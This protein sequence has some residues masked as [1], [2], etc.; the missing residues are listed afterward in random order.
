MALS[1]C[2]PGT[3]PS[4]RGIPAA[5]TAG[6]LPEAVSALLEAAGCGDLA[7]GEAATASGSRFRVGPPLLA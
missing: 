2:W 3:D 5:E 7:P 6:D 1:R 4:H